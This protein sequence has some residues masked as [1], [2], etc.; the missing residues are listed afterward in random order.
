MN[1]DTIT[2]VACIPG[3]GGTGSNGSNGNGTGNGTGTGNDPRCTDA[4]FAAANPDVCGSSAYLVLKPSS[5]IIVTLGSVQFAPFLYQN[6]VETPLTSGVLFGTSDPTVFLVGA[7]SG[8]G[9][10]LTPGDVVVTA[11][12]QGLT[13]SATVTVVDSAIG[14]NDTPVATAILVDNSK[15]SSLSFGGPFISRLAAAKAVATSYAGAILQVS[16]HPK[17]SISIF[18]FNDAPTQV[19]SGFITNTTTLASQIASIIQSQGD[20]DF[21]TA[22]TSAIAALNATSAAEKVL[23]VISD[24]EQT[25]TPTTQDVLNISSA[26]T[27]TGG[28]IIC[29]GLRA[30]TGFDLLERMAT[31][32]FFIN[33]TASNFNDSLGG[34]SFLKNAVCA[35]SCVPTGDFYAA[36]ASLDYSSYENWSVVSG[37]TNLLGNGFLDLLPGN[38]LYVELAADNHP[39]IIRTIDTFTLNPGD[40]YDIQFSLGG[41][42][43]MFTP[44][45]N[46]VVKVYVKDTTSGLNLFEHVI[47][48]DWNSP[49]QNFSFTFTAQYAATVRLY[50]EQQIAVG[51]TGHFAGNLLDNITFKDVST[52]VTLL[53]DDFNEENETYTPPACGD[54]AARAAIPDA[55][56]P[57]I[58]FINYAGGSQLTGETYKYAVSYTTTQGETALSSVISTATLTPVAFP[59]QAT[60]VGNIFPDPSVYPPDRITKIR[61]WRNDASGSSTLYLLA[62]INAENINYIDIE[63]HAQF[64]ARVDTGIVAPVANTTA[65]AAGALGHGNPVNCYTPECDP[66]TAVGVQ[67][68]DTSPLPN[69]ETSGGSSTGGTVFNSTQQACGS[70]PGSAFDINQTAWGGVTF[71]GVFA[72]PV[73][74]PKSVATDYTTSN[75]LPN[76]AVIA[77]LMTVGLTVPS[78][79]FTYT[80]EWSDDGVT[81][82]TMQ[83][84]TAPASTFTYVTVFGIAPAA[85]ALVPLCNTPSTHAHYRLT[86]TGGDVSVNEIGIGIFN[87]TSVNNPQVC[88]SASATGASQT[89]ADGR[90]TAAAQNQLD[91]YLA[92][93]CVS[94]YGSNKQY[95]AKC[96]CGSLGQDVTQSASATSF[97]SQ[98]DADARAL[99]L[100]T[101]AANALLVCTLSNNSQLINIPASPAGVPASIYPSVKYVSGFSGNSTTIVLTLVGLSVRGFEN[102]DILLMS[103]TGRVCAIKAHGGETGDIF[104]NFILVFADSAAT[105]LPNNAL[106]TNGGHYKPTQQGSPAA[107]P[108]CVPAPAAWLTTLN[109]LA[110]QS[111]NGSWSLWIR[112][113]GNTAGASSLSGWDLTIS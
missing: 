65:V 12:Y 2:N 34:L 41:N 80:I 13:A 78:M 40:D 47:S 49:F 31:G 99:A 104:S 11:S 69:I 98:D 106:P 66:T 76:I 26:F 77:A 87:S 63:D 36:T 113:V 112:V 111:P 89:E 72:A 95:V 70:C 54:S 5:S 93:N 61:I 56:N 43:E 55:E 48:V 6:G 51:Y 88:K 10:G 85:Y 50:F 38:G 68:P 82:T 28:V 58:A 108:G 18:S 17:D 94:A 81:W 73:T 35:G 90:A 91:L 53:F 107:F 21:T 9:T 24:G 86:I 59:I 103:P 20:T 74:W 62:E 15:S 14:C 100:A 44:T 42:S 64:L 29:V 75:G 37:Q 105:A 92:E 32:G 60:L 7:S 96:P 45:A 19:S 25:D 52:L 102:F 46:A 27:A 4:A 23:L 16:G 97:C 67:S 83:T 84:G 8:N 1:F 71:G 57:T 22:L 33:A 109:A 79:D 101:A 3:T 39:A 30:S 110:G